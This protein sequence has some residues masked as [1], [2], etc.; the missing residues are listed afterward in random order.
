M[1]PQQELDNYVLTCNLAADLAEEGRPID[2]YSCLL[3]GLRHV[4]EALGDDEAWK[5]NLAGRWRQAA[6]LYARTHKV[7]CG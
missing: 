2:G 5:G 4:D 7:R 1:I 3:R 6:E